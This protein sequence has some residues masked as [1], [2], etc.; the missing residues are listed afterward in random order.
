MGR[1][2]NRVSHRATLRGFTDALADHD[3][4]IV[5]DAIDFQVLNDGSDLL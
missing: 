3:L 5:Q 2:H 1:T 4:R